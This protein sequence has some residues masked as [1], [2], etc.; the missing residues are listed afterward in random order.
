MLQKIIS[1]FLFVTL[2][3]R[4]AVAKNGVSSIKIHQLSSKSG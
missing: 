4:V 1:I 3:A 2:E